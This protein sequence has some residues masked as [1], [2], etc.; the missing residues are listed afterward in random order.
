MLQRKFSNLGPLP[1]VDANRADSAR[2]GE[3]PRTA[4]ATGPQ[5]SE[6]SFAGDH[7]HALD[8]VRHSSRWSDPSLYVLGLTVGVI[9]IVAVLIR[10]GSW[11]AEP[12][13]GLVF[14]VIF[15]AALVQHAID[16]KLRRHSDC[17]PRPPEP[18]APSGDKHTW[19]LT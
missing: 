17:S 7:V 15:G 1:A 13:L 6:K 3:T 4:C 11:G 5:R 16:R 12:T 18:P 9:P 8:D 10:G 14:C 2:N 19:S